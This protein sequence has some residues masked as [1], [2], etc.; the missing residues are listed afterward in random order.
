MKRSEETIADRLGRMRQEADA[1]LRDSV[2]MV[3]G[4]EVEAAD[5]EQWLDVAWL[6]DH[7]DDLRTRGGIALSLIPAAKLAK[8]HERCKAL[9]V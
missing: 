5:R 1:N 7:V 6:L 2:W 8:F 9:D 4:Q 3:D